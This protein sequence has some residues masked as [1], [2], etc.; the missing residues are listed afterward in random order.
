GIWGQTPAGCLAGVVEPAIDVVG[1]RYGA[2]LIR[3]GSRGAE[4]VYRGTEA[5]AGSHRKRAAGCIRPSAAGAETSKNPGKWAGVCDPLT[6][7]EWQVPHISRNQPVGDIEVARP[8][9]RA[10][11]AAIL[12]IARIRVQRFRHI[13][14][15]LGVGVGDAEREITLKTALDG[16]GRGRYSVR[17][18]WGCGTRCSRSWDTATGR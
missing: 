9:P 13:V 12:G 14:D 15:A 4:R 17:C 1:L 7:T 5:A 8:H 3:Y 6:L 18:Q 16:K 11:I 2:D 10:V